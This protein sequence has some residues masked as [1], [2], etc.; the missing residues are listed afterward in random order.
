MSVEFAARLALRHHRPARERGARFGHENAASHAHFHAG[1]LRQAQRQRRDG[2]NIVFRFAGQA[3]DEIE[4]HLRDA[5][6]PGAFG[7][8]EECV[9][10][11]RFAHLPAQAFPPG[12]RRQR[13]GLHFARGEQREQ[14]LTQR[15]GAHRGGG[16]LAA[17]PQDLLAQGHD[18]RMVG[19]RG[20][21]QSHALRY[22]S[23][24]SMGGS[25]ASSE[26]QRAGR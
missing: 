22:C 2:G 9:I 4:F 7:R 6:A 24:R 23:P 8:R 14:L 16:G 19:H 3:D 13:D 11:E 18:L 1:F 10:A 20:A 26:R 12:F 5:G 15:V 25:S 21:D 17:A